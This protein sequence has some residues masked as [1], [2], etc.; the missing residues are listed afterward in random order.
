VIFP[1]RKFQKWVKL[2]L[3]GTPEDMDYHPATTAKD[4]SRTST[5]ICNITKVSS[6]Q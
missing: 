2:L 1:K 6:I 5:E 3:E 4:P